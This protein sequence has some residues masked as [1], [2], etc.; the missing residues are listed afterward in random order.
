MDLLSVDLVVQV[1]GSVIAGG[2]GG[3]G[4]EG[5]RVGG[6]GGAGSPAGSGGPDPDGDGNDGAAGVGGLLCLF[7]VVI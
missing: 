5:G 2:N 7:V 3:V 1:L 6:G 4:P